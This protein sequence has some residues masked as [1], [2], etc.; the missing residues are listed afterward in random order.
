MSKLVVV[1]DV[2]KDEAAILVVLTAIMENR[3]SNDIKLL[4]YYK[5]LS[6]NFDASVQFIDR[7]EVEMKVH[8]LQSAAML[9][10]KST[11]IRSDHLPYGVIAKVNKIRKGTNIAF[12]SNFAYVTI[13]AERR[14]YV[15][16]KV[17]D[18]MEAHFQDSNHLVK[19]AIEDISFAGIAI[20]APE[21]IILEEETA[22]KV[23]I[24]LPDGKVEVPGKLI[25]VREGD[26]SMKYIFELRADTKSERLIFQFI[27]KQQ[28]KILKELKDL[29]S[30]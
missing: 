6:V 12:L 22:G 19:G 11:F 20:K 15:R 16:V 3:L 14:I 23:I 29:A 28:S 24:W 5:G 25:N 1:E 8:D 18:K 27:F 10:Q 9:M 13:P 2:H 26:V 7:N 30:R 21:G 17:S 4:N